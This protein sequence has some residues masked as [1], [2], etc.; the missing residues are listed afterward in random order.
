MCDMLM[1][2]AIVW[3][4]GIMCKIQVEDGFSEALM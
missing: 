2:V 4:G 1:V 3:W